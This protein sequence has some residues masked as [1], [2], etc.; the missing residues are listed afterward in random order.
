MEINQ[1]G[2]LSFMATD[3][4]LRLL[5]SPYGHTHPVRTRFSVRSHSDASQNSVLEITWAQLVENG[6]DTNE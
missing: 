4:N 3:I 6:H 5:M 2:I 1:C